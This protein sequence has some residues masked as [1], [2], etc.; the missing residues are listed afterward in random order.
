MFTAE[1]AGVRDAGLQYLA[2]PWHLQPQDHGLG[3][4]VKTETAVRAQDLAQANREGMT[5]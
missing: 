1:G 2:G 5:V 4:I 3:S